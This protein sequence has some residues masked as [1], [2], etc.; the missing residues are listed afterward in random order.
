M[1]SV[2]LLISGSCGVLAILVYLMWKDATRSEWGQLTEDEKRRWRLD[3]EKRKDA[4]ESKG[5]A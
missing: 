5:A 4:K 1:D 2:L 3:E